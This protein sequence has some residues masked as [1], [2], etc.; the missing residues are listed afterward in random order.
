[1]AYDYPTLV[2]PKSQDGSIKNWVNRPDIPVTTILV[3][4][5]ALIYETLRVREMR[6]MTE[7]SFAKGDSEKALPAGFL[8][9]IKFTPYGWGDPLEYWH[10]ETYDPCM[11]ETG[12]MIVGTPSRWTIIGETAYLDVACD[13]AFAGRLLYYVTPAPLSVSN[14]TNFLT[15]RYPTLVRYACMNKAFEH[16]KDTT[17]ATEY[18]RYTMAALGGV[19]SSD[20][21]SRRGQ[22]V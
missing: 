21:L 19:A 13:E 15:R 8:D 16:M 4:A 22:N 6:S 10:E 20:D 18:L 2:G 17:R 14:P 12:A 11:D 5:E 9:P 7:F 1:M 3:E